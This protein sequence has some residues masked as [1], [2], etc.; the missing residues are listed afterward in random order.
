MAHRTQKN[1]RTL[2]YTSILL[3]HRVRSALPIGTGLIVA[4]IPISTVQY[5]GAGIN[6]HSLFLQV[7]LHLPSDISV[8]PHLPH[9]LYLLHNLHLHL[10]P[11]SKG[12]VNRTVRCAS[13]VCMEIAEYFV[14]TWRKRK[15]VEEKTTAKRKDKQ[16]SITSVPDWYPTTGIFPTAHVFH[17]TLPLTLICYTVTGCF[18]KLGMIP[19]VYCRKRYGLRKGGEVQNPFCRRLPIRGLGQVGTRTTERL[20]SFTFIFQS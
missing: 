17:F 13:P 10:P 8:S 12:D 18:L 2:I 3:T 15:Y 11:N 1:T 14:G 7:Y 4:P 16:T 19:T 5:I 6:L 9:H 20:S